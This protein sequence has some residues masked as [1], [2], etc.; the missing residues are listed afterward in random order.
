MRLAVSNLLWTPDLDAAV[1][2]LLNRRGIDAID[3]AP[4][5]YFDDLAAASTAGGARGAQLLET[6]RR[7]PSPECSRCCTARRA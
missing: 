5:R 6:A 3:V 2:D 4:T 1:A 7:S